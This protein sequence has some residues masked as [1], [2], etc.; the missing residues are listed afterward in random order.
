M[1]RYMNILVLTHSP[2]PYQIELFDAITRLSKISL[3]VIYLYATDPTR[4]W[5]RQKPKH[6]HFVVSDQ[7]PELP[8]LWEKESD[9]LVV[10]YYRH[11]V[12]ATLMEKRADIG[13]AWT[14]WGERPGF[15]YPLLGRL[16]RL[17]YLRALHCSK[18]PIWGVGEFAIQGYQQEFGRSRQYVNLPYY[19]DLSRFSRFAQS[20]QADEERVILFSGSLTHRKGVDL[21]AKAFVAVAPKCSR[22]RLHLLGSGELLGEL[23]SI[24]APVRAQISFL[25][26]KDWNELPAVYA[27]AD[28]LCTPSRYDGWGLVVPEGL[29]AGLPVIATDRMGSA[30]DLLKDGKN[31]WIIKANDLSGLIEAL[32]KV[33]KLG[34]GDLSRMSTVARLSVEGHSL[35]HGAKQFAAACRSAMD[36]WKT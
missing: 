9:L 31:G 26:F 17:W 13:K 2:S 25:G 15:K 8:F 10:N 32:H 21:L 6:E 20:R 19:S 27:G 34:D 23:H 4:S 3:R 22:L 16:A 30:L 1:N 11:H 7:Q 14:F 18:T 24:L 33:E 12:S 28:I 35:E 36:N 29:A 5:V